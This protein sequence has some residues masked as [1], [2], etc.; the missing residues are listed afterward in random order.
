MTILSETIASKILVEPFRDRDG[1]FKTLVID[2]GRGLCQLLDEDGLKAEVGLQEA[3]DCYS[4]VLEHSM[5]WNYPSDFHSKECL[6]YEG[7]RETF[8]AIDGD[9]VDRLKRVQTRLSRYISRHLRLIGVH[10]NELVT[11]FVISTYFM[12]MFNYAPRL[13]IRGDTNSGKSTLLHTL[14]KTCYRGSLTGNTTEAALFR[15]IAN[16]GITPLLDEFQDYS[17]ETRNGIKKVLK[18]GNTRGCSVQRTEKNVKGVFLP[19]SYDIFGPLALIIQSGV[20]TVPEE[21]LNRSITIIMFP[22][23]DTSVPMEPDLYEL[24]EIRDELYTIRSMWIAEPERIR[25]E[26]IRKE[27]M[28]QLQSIEG[29]EVGG[30]AYH[31]T[32]RCR[33]IMGTMLT[34]AKMAG[35]EEPIV[36]AFAEMQGVLIDDERDSNLGRVFSSILKCAEEYIEDNP[37][38]A[39]IYDALKNISTSDIALHYRGLLRE[40]GELGE[41]EKLSTRSVTNMVKDMGFQLRRDKATNK[42]IISPSGLEPCFQFNLGKYGTQNAIDKYGSDRTKMLCGKQGVNGVHVGGDVCKQLN[43]LTGKEA[44]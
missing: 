37:I 15:S 5:D 34:V 44:V 25:F 21:V 40:E 24:R 4:F 3:E 35:L 1:E 38:N 17:T 41:Y 28:T 22:L 2:R 29:I 8:D 11:T 42:S 20:S 36:E 19:V 30:K 9:Y 12:P 7:G 16:T 43:N 14:G 26:D 6:G 10:D 33:D 13:I 27:A 39:G 31:F 18:N 32:N 23:P